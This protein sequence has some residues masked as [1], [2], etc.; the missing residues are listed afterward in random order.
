MHFKR[1]AVVL[2]PHHGLV[3]VIGFLSGAVPLVL[4][5]FDHLPLQLVPVL[6]FNAGLELFVL[7]F[8]LVDQ[9]G[10]FHVLLLAFPLLLLALH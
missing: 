6:V 8:I 9:S 4:L 7:V 10:P 1:T 3:V 5:F 2:V